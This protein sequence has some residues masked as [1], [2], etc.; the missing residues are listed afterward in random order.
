MEPIRSTLNTKGFTYLEAAAL[1]INPDGAWHLLVASAKPVFAC[2]RD[3]DAVVSPPLRAHNA[4]H[5]YVPLAPLCHVFLSP[6][7][8]VLC[9]AIDSE[10]SSVACPL[11]TFTLAYDILVL[12]VGCVPCCSVV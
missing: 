5:T 10:G 7:R 8:T 3:S 6:E 2:G 9:R 4:T 12:A 11:H 1:R